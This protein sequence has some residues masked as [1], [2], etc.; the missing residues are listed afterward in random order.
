M[1]Y[2]KRKKAPAKKKRKVFFCRPQPLDAHNLLRPETL[3]SLFYMYRFTGDK[4]YRDWGWQIFLAFE[5]HTKVPDAGYSSIHNVKDAGNP[6]FRDKME[7]FFLSETLK[8][9]YLLFSD[10]PNLISLDK[11]VFNS[12]GH[13]L[14]IDKVAEAEL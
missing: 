12:E 14:P 2:K 3:E 4:K 1:T 5:K 11:F 7:S 8:Y 6:R 10:D 13:P 9:L